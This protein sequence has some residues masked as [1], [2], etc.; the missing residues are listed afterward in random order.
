LSTGEVQ[1]WTGPLAGAIVHNATESGW[2]SVSMGRDGSALVAPDG[3]VLRLK[4][5]GQAGARLYQAAWVSD[6]GRTVL[7]EAWYPSSGR[8]EPATWRC[9]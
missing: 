7:G 5:R 1:V 9:D 4:D 2:L 3:R 8:E 6:D